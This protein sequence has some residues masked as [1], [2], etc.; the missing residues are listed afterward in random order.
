MGPRS[1]ISQASSRS[2]LRALGA[3]ARAGE[4]AQPGAGEEAAGKVSAA[5]PARRRPA[6]AASSSE[7]AN[8]AFGMQFREVRRLHSENRRVERGAAQREVVEGD[9]EE[10]VVA[11]H[12]T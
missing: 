7:R 11:V 12:P 9:V 10:R 2:L 4:K 5:V 8:F 6:T 1:A 3:G